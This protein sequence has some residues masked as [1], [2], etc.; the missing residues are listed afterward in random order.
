M[1]D[2][3]TTY[4]N[5]HIIWINRAVDSYRWYGFLYTCTKI[6][7]NMGPVSFGTKDTMGTNPK[8]D[9]QLQKRNFEL[10]RNWSLL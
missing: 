7:Q 8:N 9:E 10:E 1:Y 2:Y 5:E 4:M 6:C 3:V